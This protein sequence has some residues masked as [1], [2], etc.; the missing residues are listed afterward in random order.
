M[1]E[2]RADYGAPGEW[3]VIPPDEGPRPL[4]CEHCF[5]EYPIER[6]IMG[7]RVR[8]FILTVAGAV[9]IRGKFCMPCPK[10][11]KW[12]EFTAVR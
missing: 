9:R 1:S 6:R 2:G 3:V 11:G 4:R 8:L 5:A 7:D 12:R 10:C